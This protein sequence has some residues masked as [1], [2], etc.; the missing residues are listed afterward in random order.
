M[1]KNRVSTQRRL[2]ATLAAFGAIAGIGS[3]CS[4]GRVGPIQNINSTP[5]TTT[6]TTSVPVTTSSTSAP[7]T[8][9]AAVV[10]QTNNG[11]PVT[12]IKVAVPRTATTTTTAATRIQPNDNGTGTTIAAQPPSGPAN[13]PTTVLS[14]ADDVAT[15]GDPNFKDADGNTVWVCP[16]GNEVIAPANESPFIVTNSLC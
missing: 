15:I 8:T 12:T 11:G 3:A 6:V 2:V 13:V 5:S 16:A 9:I 1:T 10:G 7:T 14:A 4:N